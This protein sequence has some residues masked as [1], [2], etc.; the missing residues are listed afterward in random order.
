M[1]KQKMAG[2]L[3]DRLR[4]APRTELDKLAQDAGI[5]IHKVNLHE[6]ADLEIGRL[7]AALKKARSKYVAE[8]AKHQ[9]T[10]D[11]TRA[12]LFQRGETGA[13]TPFDQIELPF[14]PGKDP[15]T[16]AQAPEAAKRKR[17]RP[18][19]RAAAVPVTSREVKRLG[20]A[21]V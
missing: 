1:G 21:R 9:A 5:A 19:K 15:Q 6:A 13:E 10:V 8:R 17:G 4:S 14:G 16:K 7:K 18:S 20:P 11:F 3:M 2:D 12:V